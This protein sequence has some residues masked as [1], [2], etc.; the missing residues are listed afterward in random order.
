[1]NLCSEF[2]WVMSNEYVNVQTYIVTGGMKC[3]G[4][5]SQ[6]NAMNVNECQW[7]LMNVSILLTGM[8]S[9]VETCGTLYGMNIFTIKS[10]LN[11]QEFCFIW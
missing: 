7:M 1:M 4:H 8:S 3:A 10:T 2:E 11:R 5:K 9:Y 6:L